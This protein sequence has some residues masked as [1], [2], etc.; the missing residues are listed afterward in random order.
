MGP[1]I[2]LQTRTGSTRL[3]LQRRVAENRGIKK[4]LSFQIIRLQR[5]E[6]RKWKSSN[7]QMHLRQPNQWKLLQGMQH[8]IGRQVAD[9][10]PPNDFLQTCLQT[11]SAGIRAIHFHHLNL[12]KRI[13]AHGIEARNQADESKQSLGW[14]WFGR[15]VAALYSWKRVVRRSLHHEQYS[16]KWWNPMRLAHNVVPNVPRN[17]T[18]QSHNKFSAHRKHPPHAQNFCICD[19]ST[20]W[21]TVGTLSA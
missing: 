9:Q 7:L 5:R 3:R 11:F 21:S 15:W 8:G 16:E 20:H 13:G 1:A 17:D 18:I 14:M 6:L 4:K 10:P 12:R 19:S 2:C